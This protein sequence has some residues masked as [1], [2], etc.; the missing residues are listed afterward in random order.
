MLLR[1]TKK[2]LI[3]LLFLV[4][5]RP[6]SAQVG[7]CPSNLDFELGDFTG[8]ECRWGKTFDG[9]PLP[10]VGPAF[11]RHTIITSATAGT[12]FYG[13]FPELCPNGSGFSLKLGNH[14]TGRDMESVSYTY[15]IPSTLSKFSMIFNY[16]VVIQEPV[17]PH[18]TLEQPRFRA[19]I[20]DESTGATIPC[21]DF[22][23]TANTAPGGFRVSPN[24]P[25]G[26]DV[27]YKDWTPITVNLNAFIG[28]TIKLEF[29]TNDC[30]Q[31]AHFGYAYVDVNTN[32]NGAIA[33]T[34]I[35][36]GDNSISL[37]APNGFA[38]YEWYSSPAFG[39]PIATTQNLVMDPA[40][41]VG[42]ILPVIVI[43]FP[44]FGCRD[45]LYATITVAP[46]PVS[47]AGPDAS[48]CQNQQAQIGVASADPILSFSW[49]P[50]SNVSNPNISNPMAWNNPPDPME[51]ILKT[52]DILT[53]CFSYDTVIVSN[54]VVDVN[55]ALSGESDFCDYGI[56]EATL[57]VTNSA[58]S[59][60]WYNNT[61]LIPGAT[62]PVYQPLAT[63]TY[64]AEIVQDGCTDKTAIVPINIHEIPLAAFTADQDT[65]CVTNN[66]FL[67][68]NASSVGDGSPL[69]FNWKFSDGSTMSDINP[70]RSFD[71]V[72]TYS[73][74]L[75]TSTGFGCKDST[76]PFNIFILPNGN[77]DFKW[78]SICIDRP[79][80]FTN[81]SNE[82]GSASVQYNW[83]FDDGGPGSTVKDPPLVTYTVGG[84]KN[85]T[86]EMTTLGCENDPVQLVKDVRVNGA[87][88]G[89]RYRTITVPEGH[90]WLIRARDTIGKNY[91]WSPQVQLT[92]YDDQSTQFIAVGNDVEYLIEITDDHTCVTTD[93]L[94][95]QILK[96]PG[97]YL[98]TAF[99]PNGDGLND[100]AIPY[101]VRMKSL[102]SFSVFNRWGNLIFRT[103]TEG[104]GWD[105]T[106]K[107][108]QQDNGVYVWMLEF[109][110]TENQ[111]VMEKGTIT[112]IR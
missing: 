1:F 111:L 96:K 81:L 14:A 17:N 18:S 87:D 106:Y 43:P 77:P 92:S 51:F 36:Q 9:L 98:P 59:V 13:G 6:G 84:A 38:A 105:G 71:V 65:G 35:C 40:P 94:L 52:T 68:T 73:V 89:I 91:A 49:T 25:A 75:V 80:L 4:V 88:A 107:G 32:C 112:I 12:D 78:D 20:T 33:G 58:T 31:G 29:I 79:V 108:M 70:T 90:N 63:G 82:N 37:S 85:I 27:L 62:N 72:G 74:Q 54:I 19:R 7:L 103:T 101:L 26:G 99:T 56:P 64:W 67:F 23:F 16:A 24:S 104:E 102:K 50:A 10:N 83:S 66:S 46:K 8:W 45:T 48:V 2:I 53:G 61:T 3:G 55:I 21:V 69:S 95:M 5:A 28:R 100:V 97:Y 109:I 86:L 41:A 42:T 15:T 34:N 57:T 93:T 110:T 11:G 22:D 39:V 76:A 47:V 60:Q 30:T 44:G